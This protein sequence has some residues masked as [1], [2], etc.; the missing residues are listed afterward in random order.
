MFQRFPQFIAGGLLVFGLIGWALYGYTS[1]RSTR[2]LAEAKADAAAACDER[3][4]AAVELVRQGYVLPTPTPVP[5]PVTRPPK[6]SAPARPPEKA[7][8][9]LPPG[10]AISS[11]PA[12][13]GAGVAAV[14]GV[15]GVTG[16]TLPAAVTVTTCDP[17]GTCD[18]D[19]RAGLV[20]AVATCGGLDVPC[21]VTGDGAF[22]VPTVPPPRVPPRWS[23]ELRAGLG[24]EGW[25]AGASVYGRSR[26]G[27]WVQAD[28]RGGAG[29]LAVRLG[30]R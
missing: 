8:E 28:D 23:A 27:G 5:P 24:V 26:W 22:P 6:R 25:A 4:R 12:A 2:A 15:T 18:V 1:H 3:V 9:P 13:R 17:P 30:P 7:A 10:G 16:V 19:V 14:T 20:R 21:T 29:G 11:E